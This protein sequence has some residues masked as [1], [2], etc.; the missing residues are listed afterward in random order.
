MSA[1]IED[2]PQGTLIRVR[3]KPRASR[4][5]IEEPKGEHGLIVRVTAP[6]VNN[7]ANQALLNLLARKLKV[8]KSAITIQSGEGS[9]TKTLLITGVSAQEVKAAFGF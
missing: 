8:P 1:W 9:R 5:A 7:Q 2:R 6:P 4:E 3:L